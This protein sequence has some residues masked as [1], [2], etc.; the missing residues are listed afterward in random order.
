MSNKKGPNPPTLENYLTGNATQ[1]QT[2][3]ETGSSGYRGRYEP[4][5]DLNKKPSVNV[6][7]YYD[8][9]IEDPYLSISLHPNTIRVI[10]DGGY[11]WE[12]PKDTLE[13]STKGQEW[14]CYSVK[15][16]ARSIMSEDF[17]YSVANDF[18]MQDLGNPVEALFNQ[19]KP[20]AP[21]LM[22]GGKGLEEGMNSVKNANNFGSTIVNGIQSFMGGF[23]VPQLLQSMGNNLNKALRVQGTRFSSYNGT[24]FSFNN[25]EMR[26]TVFS[27][28]VKDEKTGGYKF[29]SVNDYIQS[30]APYVMGDYNP[31]Q[32]DKPIFNN[33]DFDKFIKEYVGFQS[34]PGGFEMNTRS[35]DVILKGTFR[36]NIGST[37][38]INNLVIKNMNV[39]LS[40]VQAKRPETSSADDS[41]T[42]P[43][44]AE[45][46]LHLGIATAVVD[47]QWSQITS[48]VGLADI[49]NKIS[50]NY[51]RSLNKQ[52]TDIKSKVN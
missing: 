35:V 10:K 36:L 5:K 49:Q 23:K 38:C 21:I 9:Q 20:Y 51:Q 17:S 3:D 42:V 1:I 16:I 39:N 25:M 2:E 27:D 22:R 4:L 46:S 48:G 24:D 7:F 19:F 13:Q 28:Y 37:Y 11:G 26:F 41:P 34:P 47:H 32:T 45:I 31:L 33:E 8:A 50:E 6:G 29:Q 12:K 14:D 15:P 40:K 30:I 18:S 52:M 44:Y 43:L